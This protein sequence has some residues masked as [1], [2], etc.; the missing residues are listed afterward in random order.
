MQLHMTKCLQRNHLSNR[1]PILMPDFQVREHHI[2]PAKAAQLPL[3]KSGKR[4]A[5]YFCYVQKLQNHR[6][7]LQ[8][9]FWD[10]FLID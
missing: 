7:I 1:T 4:L 3:L 6:T 2:S 5:K 9:L 10:E 8:T